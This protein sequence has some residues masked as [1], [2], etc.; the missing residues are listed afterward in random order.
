[1]KENTWATMT[2]QN[3]LILL[4]IWLNSY[5]YSPV[6][7]YDNDNWKIKRTVS[8]IHSGQMVDAASWWLLGRERLRSYNAA[9]EAAGELLHLTLDLQDQK[10]A[11]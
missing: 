10:K 6:A 2:P 5:I 9:V 11:W 8:G 1:M 3:A 7:R 4:E